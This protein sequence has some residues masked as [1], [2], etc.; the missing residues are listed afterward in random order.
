MSFCERFECGVILREGVSHF[1]KVQTG[2]RQGFMPSPLLFPILIDY[3]M[4]ITNERSRGG[5]QWEIF[6]GRLKYIE[7]LDYADDLDV[8]E[9]TQA[10]IREKT[11][12]VWQTARRVGLEINAPK[13]KVMCINTTLDAPLTIAGETLE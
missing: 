10:Q 13:T 1:F 11:E 3:V 5:I 12:K 2:V 4:R 8:L 9:C 6:S 7:D